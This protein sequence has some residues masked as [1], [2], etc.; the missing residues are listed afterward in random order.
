[1]KSIKLKASAVRYLI[2]FGLVGTMAAC[3]TSHIA[4][5][6][7]SQAKSNIQAAQ[8]AGAQ[9]YAPDQ[10]QKAQQELKK[11]KSL[12][13]KKN[14]KKAGQLTREASVD[15]K[16]AML[17]ALSKKAQ[18]SN[19][20]LPKSIQQLQQET[21]NMQ[22][23]M[24]KQGAVLTF[25]NMLFDFG[26]ADLH[27]GG[28]KTISKLAQ[29][30]NEH[31]NLKVLIQG[32]TDSR[33]PTGYNLALSNRRAKSVKQALTD[34]G[35]SDSRINTI[36]YGEEDPVATNRTITGRQLNRRVEIVIS[37][38]NEPTNSG[39]GNMIRQSNPDTTF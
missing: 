26:K 10:L 39:Q 14:N 35:V 21:K 30:L 5:P 19:S 28:K 8:Q 13:K 1:M 9:Q 36:G 24:T 37:K 20:Q 25:G 38:N 22:A 23:K 33:G 18:K 3:A 4:A 15:A 16:L 29:F 7:T 2:L 12:V 34:D 27:P 17:T 6:D 11:A 31:S 32:Y